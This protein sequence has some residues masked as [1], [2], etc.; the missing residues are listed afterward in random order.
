MAQ[1]LRA[2]TVL[3]EDPGSIP[4]THMEFTIVCNSN[5]RGFS[6]LNCP[7]PAPDTHVVHLFT[8]GKTFIHI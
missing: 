6:A 3:S 4:S 2:P 1:Q 7:L 8:F 5:S